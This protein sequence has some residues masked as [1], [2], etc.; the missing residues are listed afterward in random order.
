MGDGAALAVRGEAGVGK[1]ALLRFAA[2]SAGDMR[3]LRA[4]GVAWEAEIAFAGALELLR[5]ILGHLA[6]LPGPQR[7]ALAGALALTPAV[8]RDRFAVGAATLGL[9]ALAAARRPLLLL[10]DDA[11]WL[12]S[13][14]LEALLF[15]ARRLTGEPVALVAAVRE[16]YP[17]ALDTSALEV[18]ALEGLDREATATL[19]SDLLGSS[20]TP[21]QTEQIYRTTRGY[22]LAMLELSRLGHHGGPVDAPLPVSQTVERAYAR[23]VER[24]GEEVR[25]M[26]V[27][28][29][30]DDSGDLAT[31]IAAAA[32]LGLDPAALDTAESLGL[33]VLADGRL[34]FRHPL[35]RSAIYQTA[36]ATARRAA[37]AALAD[38]L[39]GDWQADRR[40]WHRS[41]GAVTPDERI[42]AELETMAVNARARSGYGAAARALERAAHLTPDPGTRARRMLAAADALW[43]AGRGAHAEALLAD[44]LERS[45]DPLLRANAQHLRGRIV[46]FRGDPLRA[47]ALLVE[48]GLRAAPHDRRLAAD[49]L[50]SAFHSA[51]FCGDCAVTATTAATAAKLAQE[52]GAGLDPRLAAFAGGALV[53]S[54]RL[55]AAEPYLRQSIAAVAELADADADPYLLASAANSHGWL[56]EY[57]A[58]GDLAGRAL[59]IAREQGALG[60]VGYVAEILSEW[61]WALGEFERAI[62]TADEARRIG[63]ETEQ[64]QVEAWSSWNLAAIA[65]LRGQR[66]RCLSY[67]E[68]AQG[69]GIRLWCNGI[70]GVD[71]VLGAL[72]LAEGDAEAAIRHLEAAVDLDATQADYTPWHLGA[73]DLVEAY[74]RAGRST[75]AARAVEALAAH[76]R[77][78]WELAALARGRGLVAGEDDFDGHFQASVEGYARLRVPF[79]EARSRLCYGERLRRGGRR[80][81]AREQLRSALA[82]FERLRTEPWSE[83]TR[84]E[85]R[86]S[87]ET[88]RARRDTAA[89]D[90]LTPQELQVALTVAA[91]LT[92]KEAGARLYLSV[93]TIEA[94]LHRTYRKLGI[95]SRDEL[96]P[97]L[98]P[99]SQ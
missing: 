30:A 34:E 78:H 62:S 73:A 43:Q 67:L 10:V 95:R 82:T 15:A 60:A 96:G 17:T 97:L 63:H 23:E 53:A 86:A 27:V 18:L 89:L 42:A 4:S 61:E 52:A 3:V 70:D 28:A 68:Q 55:A 83:R 57:P 45:S 65:S 1:T 75:S 7:Q 47:R 38:V 22:P 51:K 24:C 40:A 39:T 35:V 56:G 91:G 9:L 94:H 99:R 31:I 2:A 90:E 36:P 80:V 66:D 58:A 16:G 72:D 14:S 29:A 85:L 12:D 20:P 46:H 50:A 19:A 6:D 92:N 88:L 44:A 69:L 13:A 37:H 76:A 87:G 81:Q 8:E 74:V 26:L 54:G 11:Q 5:P 98:G 48:E 77:Q 25:A 49:M 32:S 33:L 71:A 41:A 59:A 84:A 21:E 79:D 64:P 93:K